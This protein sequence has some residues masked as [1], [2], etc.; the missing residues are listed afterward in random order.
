M[1][2]TTDRHIQ[3]SFVSV[4][5]CAPPVIIDAAVGPVPTRHIG[6]T[7]LMLNNAMQHAEHTTVTC[8]HVNIVYFRPAGLH[9]THFLWHFHWVWKN[10]V[11]RSCL[12]LC[13]MN[14]LNSVRK[15]VLKNVKSIHGYE[16]ERRMNPLPLLSQE[17][18]TT[19][20]EEQPVKQFLSLFCLCLFCWVLFW[21]SRRLL[22]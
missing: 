18:M 1:L 5:Q 6:T 19:I 17:S 2:P 3:R 8:L 15:T 21:R 14:A 11:S 12:K 10:G 22:K 7:K 9:A 20:S 16:R 4:S 13:V